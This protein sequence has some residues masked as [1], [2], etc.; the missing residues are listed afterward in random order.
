MSE[1]EKVAKK[2]HLLINQIAEEII[3]LDRKNLPEM[4]KL[5]TSLKEL[6]EYIRSAQN[7][8]SEEMSADD[9]LSAESRVED[10]IMKESSDPDQD[11]NDVSDIIAKVQLISNTWNREEPET[12][13]ASQAK[14][15]T[16]SIKL[17]PGVDEQLLEEFT[18][19]QLAV[20]P[21]IEDAILKY[22][23]DEQ[24]ET[25]ATL[26]RI[27]HTMKGDAGVCGIEDIGTVCHKLEDYI[28]ADQG[29]GEALASH[30][31][32][33]ILLEVKDWLGDYLNALS[34]KEAPTKSL[35][36]LL[37]KLTNPQPQD[38]NPPNKAT[39]DSA[40]TMIADEEEKESDINDGA[41]QTVQ[42]VPINDPDLAKEFIEEANEHFDAIDENLLVLENDPT[43]K[44]AVSAVF[45]AFHTIKGVAGFL[46]LGVI[47][48]LAHV[49]ETLLDQ[50]RK[51]SRRFEGP[52]SEII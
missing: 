22:E 20:L 28:D 42:S 18:E 10:I 11:F 9:I 16:N 19:Q 1:K 48:D 44:D 47:S 50:V 29:D 26:R 37:E 30:I 51:G 21:E 4:G 7:W 45:R 17:P 38:D 3:L 25:L 34:R 32:P 23:K 41:K 14:S 13:T 36:S 49:A 24:V 6:S 8:P 35:D 27:V 33:D 39:E 2:I 52:V 46:G 31:S 40:E 5:C 43:D 12:D 15:Q